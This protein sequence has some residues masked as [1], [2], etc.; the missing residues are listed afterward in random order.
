MSMLFQ[1]ILWRAVPVGVGTALVGF[2]LRRFYL[3]AVEMF[4][5]VT[6]EESPEGQLQ[7]PLLFGLAGFVIAAAVACVRKDKPAPTNQQSQTP[8]TFP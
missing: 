8:V 4:T 3:T 1:R 2:G 7:G 6:L 5:S